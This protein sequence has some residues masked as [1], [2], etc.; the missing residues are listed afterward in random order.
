MSE[1]SE[2]GSHKDHEEGNEGEGGSPSNEGDE[3]VSL[4]PLSKPFQAAFHPIKEGSIA[5]QLEVHVCCLHACSVHA[6]AVHR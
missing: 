6:S 3:E 2:W 4:S 1:S 5:L